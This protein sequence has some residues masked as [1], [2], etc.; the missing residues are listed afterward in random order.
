[1][2]VGVRRARPSLSHLSVLSHVRR[3]FHWDKDLAMAKITLHKMIR[4]MMSH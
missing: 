3:S 4:G 1:M 2:P